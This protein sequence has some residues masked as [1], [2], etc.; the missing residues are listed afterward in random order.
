MRYVFA[1]FAILFPA[2]ASGGAFDGVYDADPRLCAISDYST[3]RLQ[4]SGNQVSYYTANCRVSGGIGGHMRLACS[5][6]DG[7]F[8]EHAS[9]RKTRDGLRLR[10]FGGARVLHRCR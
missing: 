2:M 6:A 8:V 3:T 10:G 9:L 5:D 7:T 1:L 4:V